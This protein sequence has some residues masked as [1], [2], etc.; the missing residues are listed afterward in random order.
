MSLRTLWRFSIAAS[1]TILA[2]C[3]TPVDP[4]PVATVQVS[5]PDSLRV[6]ESREIEATAFDALNNRLTGRRVNWNSTAPGVVTVDTSGVVR[7]V[8]VGSA[9]ISATIEGKVGTATWKV[10]S[11]IDR[12]AVAPLTAD[13]PLGTSRQLAANVLDAD[14]VA[15]SGRPVTWS[16]SNSSVATVS[17]TGLVSAVALG[18][19]TI[20]ATVE[21]KSGTATVDVIDPVATVRITPPVAQTLRVGGKL[22]LS[23]IGLNAAGQTLPGRPVKWFSSNPNVASV[24]EN[25]GEV[26]ALAVGNV[27]ITAEIDQRTGGLGVNVTL[28]P[29]GSV[30]LT[31]TTLQLF[32]LE[33]RQLTLTSTDSTGAAITNFQGRTVVY[34][35]SNLPVASVTNQG[36]VIAVDTGSAS[37]TVTVDQV[38]S[39]PVAITVKLVPVATVT[40]NPNP[41]S[42]ACNSTLQFQATLRDANQNIIS[43]RPVVWVSSDTAKATITAAGVLTGHKLGSLQVTATAEGVV[44]ISN[45]NIVQSAP[46]SC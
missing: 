2:T 4:T 35:S 6:G 45:V 27:T 33:Q 34:Q 20:T 14:G 46:P 17:T 8:A 21:T 32:R 19:V 3:T 43:G 28:I 1:F 41:A 25:T 24:N 9:I 31:P 36:V 11:A 39:A 5:G 22:Q 37:I 18:R 13:V 42:V 23:A 10:I 29:V 44:G 15:L 7:G 30:S 16:S 38:T 40:V 12:V 26:T